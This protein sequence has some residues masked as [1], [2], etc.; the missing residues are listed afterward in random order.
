MWAEDDHAQPAS[1]ESFL[2]GSSGC[3]RSKPPASSRGQHRSNAGW[4]EKG[5]IELDLIRPALWQV[6]F[7]VFAFFNI[8]KSLFAGQEASPRWRCQMTASVAVRLSRPSYLVIQTTCW[9]I[10]LGE[11]EVDQNHVPWLLSCWCRW[12]QSVR[13][14]QVSN[15]EVLL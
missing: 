5:K 14:V 3:S 8:R 4:R 9:N 11:N 1:G 7:Y 13:T 15:S 6:C 2:C 10:I 12:K